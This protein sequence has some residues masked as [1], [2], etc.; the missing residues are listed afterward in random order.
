MTSFAIYS[1]PF[2][3][4]RIGVADGLIV[5]IQKTTAPGPGERTP[6]TER[7]NAQLTEYLAGRRRKFDLPYRFH[8]T[9]FQEE[10]WHALEQIPYGTTRTYQEI[11][12]SIHRPK[13]VRAVGAAISKNPL[14][15]VVPCH[16]VLGANGRLT[17]Y[18]G[19]LAMKKDLLKIEA[20]S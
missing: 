4:L 17:G 5:S 18:A 7:A 14:L 10:V 13:A 16:R 9:A 12:A 6:L 11:A 8:G 15:I 1:F 3:N 20:N 19:G 2:G